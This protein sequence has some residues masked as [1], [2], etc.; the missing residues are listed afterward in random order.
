MKHFNYHL[1]RLKI[2]EKGYENMLFSPL[3]V[4]ILFAMILAGSQGSVR[5]TLLLLLERSEGDLDDYLR[6]LT[7]MLR[8]E[9][10]LPDQ[11]DTETFTRCRLANSFWYTPQETIHSRFEQ[12][13]QQQFLAQAYTFPENPQTTQRQ[14]D[15]WVATHTQQMIP[16]LPLQID[17]NT[18][19]VLLS[20]LYLKATWSRTFEDTQIGDFHL[21]D[22]NTTPTQYMMLDQVV[23][24]GGKAYHMKKEN[25]AAFAFL[26]KDER[27]AFVM[28]LPNEKDGLNQFL[29]QI[30]P[31]SFEEWKES[32]R[33]ARSF[34]LKI[35]KFEIEDEFKLSSFAKQLDLMDLFTASSDLNPVFANP[36]LPLFFSEVGQPSK[37]KV[38]EKGL[39]ASAV[40]YAVMTRGGLQSEKVIFEATHPFYF[41]VQDLKFGRNLFEGIFT[42]PTNT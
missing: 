9:K 24:S 41:Q 4:E 33:P 40:S 17:A 25:F 13:L 21:L 3:S 26:S 20:T 5:K 6:Q 35:P 38:H 19:M 2:Q 42:T 15:Q 34:F 12:S 31:Y 7:E 32:F 18:V 14:I 16:E 37:L 28:Y 39:E 1:L 36:T 10:I 11:I 22:G 23:G 30:T 27:I 29:N 8:Y